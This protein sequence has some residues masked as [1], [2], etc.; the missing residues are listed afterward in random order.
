[1]SMK[2]LQYAAPY[3]MVSLAYMQRVCGVVK[4]EFLPKGYLPYLPDTSF[5]MCSYAVRQSR[6][7]GDYT[8]N[9]SCLC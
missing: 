6:S 9:S 3:L 7:H 1:M 4:E 5:V 2:L 8:D